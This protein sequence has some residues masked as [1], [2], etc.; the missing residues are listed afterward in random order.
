[1][2]VRTSCIVE[3]DWLTIVGTDGRICQTHRDLMNY[4]GKRSATDHYEI[5]LTLL[6]ANWFRK[7]SFCQIQKHTRDDFKRLA[8]SGLH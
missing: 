8:P 1:M 2:L 6:Y 7:T 3:L 4:A 5:H